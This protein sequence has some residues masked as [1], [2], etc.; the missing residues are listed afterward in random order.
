M[1]E[2]LNGMEGVMNHKVLILFDNHHLSL[3]AVT[4]QGV[5]AFGLRYINTMNELTRIDNQ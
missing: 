5:W 1:K 3:P 4:L 2:V